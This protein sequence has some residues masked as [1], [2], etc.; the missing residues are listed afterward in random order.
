MTAEIKNM[1][2]SVMEKIKGG[3][4]IPP[5]EGQFA[6]HVVNVEKAVAG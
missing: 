4:P 1:L 3:E 6:E 2:R 5:V